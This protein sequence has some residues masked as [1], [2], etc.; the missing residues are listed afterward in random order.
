M[1]DAAPTPTPSPTSTPAPSPAPAPSAGPTPTPAPGPSPTPEPT[2]APSAD[3]R[4][5][6]TDE[7]GKKFAQDSTDI[8]HLAKRAVDM[9]QKLSGAIVRPGK[10][11]K[12]DSPEVIAYRKALDIPDKPEG[13]VVG[14]PEHIPEDVFKSEAIQGRIGA[15]QK[16]LHDTGAPKAVSD[17]VFKTYFQMEAQAAADVVKADKD[18][19][20]ASETALKTEWGADY[21]KN[22][23]FA[24]RAVAKLFGDQLTAARGIED[25]AGR[26]VLDNPVMLKAFAQIGREMGEGTLGG[27]MTD[28]ERGDVDSQIST[29]RTQIADAQAKGEGRR[30]NELYQ[31]EQALL[32][33]KGNQPIVGANS[34]AA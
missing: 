33:K 12:P 11:A 23:E 25:K 6:I 4:A 13:Y 1:A 19:A 26:F 20:A 30:A 8:N 31:Q 5:A 17:A 14:R 2:P 7:D 24:N 18:Y 28:A 27:A 9:R 21:D 34:R 15:M 10:D 22:K 16:V 32:A 29:L 3:W